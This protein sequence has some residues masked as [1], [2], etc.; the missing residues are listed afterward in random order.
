MHPSEAAMAQI[1]KAAAMVQ[2]QTAQVEVCGG[3]REV[4]GG[5]VLEDWDRIGLRR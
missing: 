4:L 5:K 3:V 2:T 1:L